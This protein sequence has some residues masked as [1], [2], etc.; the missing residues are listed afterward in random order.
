MLWE[1]G[2][3]RIPEKYLVGR[4]YSTNVRSFLFAR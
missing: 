1:L 2:R 4:S 3:E